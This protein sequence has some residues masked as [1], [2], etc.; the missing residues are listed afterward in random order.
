[1]QARCKEWGRKMTVH[2]GQDEQQKSVGSGSILPFSQRGSPCWKATESLK[3]RSKKTPNFSGV[4]LQGSE[5]SCKAG[6][7]PLGQQRAGLGSCKSE[8]GKGRH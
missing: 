5:F 1:M 4:K 2:E 3:H 6:L 8:V 7:Q